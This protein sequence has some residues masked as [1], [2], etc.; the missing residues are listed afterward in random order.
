MKT[1]IIC[2]GYSLKGVD[3]SKIEGHITAVNYACRYV[4][5]DLLCAFDDPVR[6]GFP[7]DNRLHTNQIYVDEH[8]L[9]CHGW[10]RGKSP[11]L[12]REGSEIFGKSGSLFCAINVLIKLGFKEI[13]VYGADMALSEDDYCHFYDTKPVPKGRGYNKYITIFKRHK[14]TK[15]FFMR[16]LMEDEKI[17]WH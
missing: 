5:Y 16:L 1:S 4:D 17:I 10:Y 2:T 6:F 8:N 15:E 11:A 9:D 13:H 7:V 12:V 3:L 14:D